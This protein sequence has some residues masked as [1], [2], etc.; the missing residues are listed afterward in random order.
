MT[1]PSPVLEA[2]V[3]TAGTSSRMGTRK[4]DL[5]YEGV[6]LLEW[7]TLAARNLGIPIH[8]NDQDVVPGLGPLGGLWTLLQTTRASQVLCLSCDMPLIHSS[9]LMALMAEE[10]SGKKAVFTRTRHGDGFPFLFPVELA[11]VVRSILDTGRR[12]LQALSS[13]VGA[14]GVAPEPPETAMNINTPED[15]DEV[16]LYLK[17]NP[18]VRKPLRG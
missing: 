1:S 13:A 11:H 2:W 8:I 17:A 12:S 5:E 3:L 14:L 16:R 18:L 15:W 7:S 4:A 10:P 9:H 6:S